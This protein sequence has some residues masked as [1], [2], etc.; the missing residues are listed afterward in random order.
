MAAFRL[1]LAARLRRYWPAGLVI[2]VAVGFVALTM[3]AS[4][5]G[6]ESLLGPVET[7]PAE[8][9]IS[10]VN[11]SRGSLFSQAETGFDRPASP[12]QETTVEPLSADQIARL[13]DQPG[14]AWVEPSAALEVAAIVDTGQLRLATTAVPEARRDWRLVDGGRLPAGP[15]EIAADQELAVG[16]GDRLSIFDPGSNQPRQLLVVGLIEPKGGPIAESNWIGRTSAVVTLSLVEELLGIDPGQTFE[17]SVKLVDGVDWAQARPGLEAVLPAGYNLVEITDPTRELILG[18]TVFVGVFVGLAILV[19]VFVIINIFRIILASQV[20]DLATLRLLGATRGQVFGRILTESVLVAAIVGIL[21]ATLAWGLVELAIPLANRRWDWQ[22]I[23]PNLTAWN[24]LIPT[25]VGLA[26][27][28]AGAL[29]PALSASRRRPVTALGQVVETPTSKLTVV[30]VILGGSLTSLALA[31]LLLLPRAGSGPS[32]LIGFLIFLAGLGFLLG[33]ALVSAGLARPFGRL[34]G[35]LGRPLAGVVWRLGAGNIGRQPAR[36]A[37]V[38]NSLLV[39]VSLITAVTI[40][41]SSFQ[42][43]GQS[44]LDHYFPSDWLVA[45]KFDDNPLASLVESDNYDQEQIDSGLA[46]ELID[47]G[48]L[49][50]PT[51]VRFGQQAGVVSSAESPGFSQTVDIG[52]FDPETIEQNFNYDFDPESAGEILAGGQ[53]LVDVKLA[54]SFSPGQTIRVDYPETGYRA[55]YT[56]GGSFVDSDYDL[57]LSNDQY[58][59]AIQRPGVTFIAG[60]SGPGLDPDEARAGLEALL[61][62]NPELAVYDLRT[63]FKAAIDRVINITLNVLRGLLGLSLVVAVLGIFST[64]I[65]S[66][67]E[68]RVELGALR[69]IGLTRSQTVAL[70]SFEGVVMALFGA[71]LGLLA[72]WLGAF[73]IIELVRQEPSLAEFLRLS[74]PLPTLAVYGLLAAAL[75]GLAALGP[76]LLVVRRSI[77]DCLSHD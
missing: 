21:S 2:G 36:S 31:G 64:L 52:G 59:A 48:L 71:V 24:W 27:T 7:R 17:L 57:I 75:G 1:G 5:A 67:R 60:D 26:A 9:R 18:L 61:A 3:L 56:V 46:D 15:C 51:V 62:D 19:A 40:L 49:E 37:A 20:R 6:R 41:A 34:L 74:L 68:R 13:A 29:L 22:L 45:E 69:A 76:A 73:V 39:G 38:A 23:S 47:S 44:L 12:S 66:I 8:F 35:W 55:D 63:D 58:L 50:A 11:Q 32:G 30:R 14:V 28:L 54:D 42:A 10:P 70:I 77:V 43:A 53:V 16:L 33:L 72:G 25:L 4:S 65:L